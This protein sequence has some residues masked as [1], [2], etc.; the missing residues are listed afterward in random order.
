MHTRFA[1]SLITLIPSLILLW[2]IFTLTANS[3]SIAQAAPDSGVVGSGTP[4]SCTQTALNTALAG[5]GSITFNCGG[6]ATIVVTATKTI[7]VNTTLDGGSV[8]TLSGGDTTGVFFIQSG[9]RL[10][11]NHLTLTQGDSG[12]GGC[13]TVF[14]TLQATQSTFTTCH[15]HT[16]W[17]FPGSGGAIYSLNGTVALTNSVVMNNSVDLD[18]GGIYLNGGQA[19]LNHVDVLSNTAWLTH[20]GSGGGVYVTNHTNFVA[21]DS[22]FNYNRIGWQGQG[23]GLYVYSS[24]ALLVNVAANDNVALNAADGGGFYAENSQFTLQ[25]GGANG[26][27]GLYDGGGLTLNNTSASISNATLSNNTASSNGGGISSYKGSL[28]LNNVIVNGN[29]VESDGGGIDLYQT[30]STFV[31]VTVNN[32]HGERNGGGINNY[33]STLTLDRFTVSGNEALGNQ[34]DGGG[35]YNDGMLVATNST[36]DHNKTDHRG[37]GIYNASDATAD[38]TNVT[39]SG[40][41]A[42]TDGGGIYSEASFSVDVTT[43]TLNGVTLKDNRA[44]QGGGVFNGNTNN[45]FVYLK[46]T[47]LADNAP[48]SC[49]GKAFSSAKYS[50][51]SDTTC[52][53]SGLG[54]HT[55]TPAQLFPLM[56]NGGNTQTH[57][58]GPASVLVNGVIGVDCPIVDQ[59]SVSRPQGP[60]CD[61]GAVERQAGDAVSA[62]WLY[63]PLIKR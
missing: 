55:H 12:M 36:L 21:S 16:N 40:N 42:K 60:G 34:G 46:N 37:G 38:L 62:P 57:L 35:I 3:S 59:R 23:G 7:S 52:T 20:T 33:W 13:V 58:P 25:G 30:P 39:L 28:L 48:G 8:I 15:S 14:G 43:V 50:L 44:N 54:N 56:N 53:L 2:L 41:T 18:G 9:A 24:T 47:V 32:N 19:T 17:I 49:Y 29:F 10:T 61:V 31:S 5:G 45:N 22:R 63:L 27:H 1:R 6:P 51:A 26:N 11:L 4:A